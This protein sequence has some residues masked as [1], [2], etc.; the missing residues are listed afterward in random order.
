[1]S[2]NKRRNRQFPFAS[3]MLNSILISDSLFTN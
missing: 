2:L 3:D 1:M